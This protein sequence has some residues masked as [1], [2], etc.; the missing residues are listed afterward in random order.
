MYVVWPDTATVFGTRGLVK[1]RA[2]ID[3]EPFRSSFMPLGDGRHMLP[4]K[5]DVRRATGKEA[6]ERLGTE[7]VQPAGWPICSRSPAH[8]PARR[9]EDRRPRRRKRP[10]M[11]TNDLLAGSGDVL[12]AG[13]EALRSWVEENR[14]RAVALAA[15]AAAVT[16]MLALVLSPLAGHEATSSSTR[17]AGATPPPY[18]TVRKGDTLAAVAERFGLTLERLRDL[19]PRVD[20]MALAPGARLRLRMSVPPVSAP[21]RQ[22]AHANPN[23][24]VSAPA[25]STA[26]R[27][28]ASQRHAPAAASTG[29]THTVAPGDTLSAIAAR[30]G[31]SVTELLQLNPEIDPQVIVAGQELALP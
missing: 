30:Y 11:S 6:E 28:P 26:A 23:K 2:T 13:G 24:R 14:L 19:N 1:V 10:A 3:G 7:Q 9:D 12:R 21:Q 25:P 16:A 31:T 8:E 5:A 4:V 22:R 18:Y 27:M 17:A 15:Y 29:R 20:P